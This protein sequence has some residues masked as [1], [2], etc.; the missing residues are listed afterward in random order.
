MKRTVDNDN[1]DEPTGDNLATMLLGRLG[2]R[3]LIQHAA[4]EGV[5]LWLSPTIS[6]I[7]DRPAQPAQVSSAE[8]PLMESV[9]SAIESSTEFEQVLR[10]PMPESGTQARPDDAYVVPLDRIFA[11]ESTRIETGD[12]FDPRRHFCHITVNSGLNPLTHYQNMECDISIPSVNGWRYWWN[13]SMLLVLGPGD[14]IRYQVNRE[15]ENI[16]AAYQTAGTFK[17]HLLPA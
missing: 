4:A 3:E 12:V 14:T 5:L 9:S 7:L 8:T 11:I 6:R 15:A 1:F 17:G 16:Q 13:Y 10:A 2:K